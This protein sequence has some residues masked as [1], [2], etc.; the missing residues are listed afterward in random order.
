MSWSQKSHAHVIGWNN[1]KDSRDN[2]IIYNMVNICQPQGK[3]IVIRVR[4][5]SI[6]QTISSMYIR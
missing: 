6:A 1:I 4:L 5:K 2:D 3:H